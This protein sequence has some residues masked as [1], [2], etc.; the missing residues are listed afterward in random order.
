M[1]GF[2]PVDRDQILTKYSHIISHMARNII[3]NSNILSRNDLEQAGV[4]ALLAAIDSYDPS[5]GSFNNYAR[6]CIRNAMLAEANKCCG[7]FMI[8]PRVR[9][10]VNQIN[11][12]RR[13][14]LTDDEIMTKLGLTNKRRFLSLTS[15]L[16]IEYTEANDQISEI[17]ELNFNNTDELL[18][19]LQ[20]V[21]LNDKELCLVEYIT[22]GCDKKYILENMDID[23]T[24]YLDI[25]N[26]VKDKIRT[27]GRAK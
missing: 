13:D 5:T 12:Y 10:Q 19:I 1:D 23:Y 3:L 7:I 26:T 9:T 18:K 17:D 22:T 6:V 8:D 11:K 14:G 21:G 15:L 20:E 25:R 27:W 2:V 4:A 16:D 24:K